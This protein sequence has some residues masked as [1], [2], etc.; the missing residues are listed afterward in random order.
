MPEPRHDIR[1]PGVTQARLTALRRHLQAEGMAGLILPRGDEH[2][3]E[4]VAAY[5]ERLAWLTGFT[6]SAGKRQGETR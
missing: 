5:A 6:G 4:Y 2:Q 3:G 1:K